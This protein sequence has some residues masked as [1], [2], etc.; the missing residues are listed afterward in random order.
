MSKRTRSKSKLTKSSKRR[1]YLTGNALSPHQHLHPR[2]NHHLTYALG[3]CDRHALN[4]APRLEG[5][6]ALSLPLEVHTMTT[7]NPEIKTKW[8]EALR[9][10]RYAQTQALLRDTKGY[11]CLGVLCDIVDPD[12]WAQVED[13]VEDPPVDCFLHHGS[14]TMPDDFVLCGVDL[15]GVDADTLANLNDNGKSFAEIADF[16]EANL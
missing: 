5:V 15:R 9:S 14:K 4:I 10:G 11:C 16:I 12:E 6:P 8:L 1:D 3:D 13:C 2:I 7:M